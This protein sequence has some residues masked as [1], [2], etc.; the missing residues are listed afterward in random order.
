MSPFRRMS[1]LDFTTPR[2]RP[3]R[4]RLYAH[5]LR[6]EP[7]HRL[8]KAEC[9]MRERMLKW[10]AEHPREHRAHRALIGQTVCLNKDRTSIEG[11]PVCKGTCFKIVETANGKLLGET[12]GGVI[13]SLDPKWVDGP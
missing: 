7:E 5:Y 9:K 12:D 6:V 8:T 11:F 1:R 10:D 4:D 2:N 3:L 13:L